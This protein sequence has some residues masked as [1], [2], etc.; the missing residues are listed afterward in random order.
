[1]QI[2]IVCVCVFICD[3]FMCIYLIKTADSY[4][5]QEVH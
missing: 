3:A 5:M 4:W 2:H 1:M